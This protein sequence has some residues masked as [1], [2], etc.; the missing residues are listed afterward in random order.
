M[1]RAVLALGSNLGDR[2]AALQGGLDSLLGGAGAPAPAGLS[3]VYETA[4]VGGPEQG[5]FLNAV[6]LVDTRDT[7]GELLARAQDAERSLGR[8]REVR[9][10]PR[11]LDV[12]VIAYGDVRDDD[13][14]LTLPHPRAHLRA[15]VL[16]PWLDLDPAAE[17]P[18]RG[19]VADLLA[20]VVAGDVGGE[21][22]LRPREDLRL[23]LPGEGAER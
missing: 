4:P 19:P 2:R 5:A 12:D 21:Q 10:G 1:T 6:L 20:E 22:E 3:A 11:T 9:W 8:V 16:K 15:F 18:G 7:P 23:R 17:L 14:D 13:P